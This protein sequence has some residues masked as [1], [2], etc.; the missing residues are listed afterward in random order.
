[1][2]SRDIVRKA[3]QIT[4][5]HLKKLIW[6]G[7]IPAFFS[8][9][10]SSLYL[11]Y[12]YHAFKTSEL[13]S[14]QADARVVEKAMGAMGVIAA[15]PG[16][17]IT[18]IIISIFFLVGY[19]ILPP[20]FHGTLIHAVMK[21]KDY[22]PIEGSVEIGVRRFFPM[23]ELGLLTGSFSIIT[24]FTEG[25]FVIRWWGVNIFLFVLPILLFVVMVGL[26]ISFLFTYAEYFIVL[27]NKK[28][29]DSIKESTVLVLSNLRK[30]F[31]IFVL[32]VLISARIILNVILVLIIPGLIVLL[33][34]YVATTLWATIGLIL[35]SIL[36]LAVLLV[37]SYLLGLFRIF[38]TAVWVLTY[39]ILAHKTKPT[40]KD[41]DLGK[42]S[43]KA[44]TTYPDPISPP[45]DP[46]PPATDIPAT[47][48]IRY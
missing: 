21:I 24:L 4:Q 41:V 37:S 44:H 38:T 43:V 14:D 46:A 39:D 1:M 48:V 5:V 16:L 25:S 35:I 32:M 12:Q 7:A 36:G 2:R 20:I 34:G 18:L 17:T 6:Y 13:F 40:I 47:M 28:L 10:V 27:D 19:I 8:V 42:G 23:F 11:A 31:L 33:G 9:V 15:H 45:P 22:E 30:T 29:M 3:W 26:I